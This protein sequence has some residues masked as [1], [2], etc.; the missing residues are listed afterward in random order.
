ME[1]EPLGETDL[2]GAAR[3]FAAEAGDDDFFG[4]RR[5]GGERE[6]FEFGGGLGAAEET[7]NAADFVEVGHAGVGVSKGES[8]ADARRAAAIRDSAILKKSA[9]RATQR[10]PIRPPPIIWLLMF[11]KKVGDFGS[12][13]RI[14]GDVHIGVAGGRL[15]GSGELEQNHHVGSVNRADGR[16]RLGSALEA[17]IPES[18][19]ALVVRQGGVVVSSA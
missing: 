12:S 10:S 19:D 14:S 17:G 15:A 1:E 2:P 7:F 4:G 8:P 5:E 11:L 18:G 6:G 9:S 3:A 13:P 16:L